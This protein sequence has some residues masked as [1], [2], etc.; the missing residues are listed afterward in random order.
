M[1]SVAREQRWDELPALKNEREICLSHIVD[2][3]LLSTSGSD[4]ESKLEMIQS[5]LECD[6]LTKALVATRQGDLVE[7]IG[8][9]G[10]ER[11]LSDAYQTG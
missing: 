6:E 3:E 10:N 2:P 5:I 7:L 4:V 1:L 8:S 9:L 11:K